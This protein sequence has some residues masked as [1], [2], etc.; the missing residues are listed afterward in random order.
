MARI[1]VRKASGELAPFDPEKIRRT[2]MHAGASPELTDK[3]VAQV[4]K[5]IYNGI[6]TSQIL[7]MTVSLLRKERPE[8]AARY[9]LKG[10]IMRLGPA[11]FEFETLVAEILNRYGYRTQRDV[12]VSGACVEHEIDIVAQKVNAD[13]QDEW[14][15]MECK[16]HNAPGIFTGLKEAM[17]T[18][19]RFIDLQ[20]GFKMGRCKR[21]DLGWLVSNTKFSERAIR[22]ATCK[23]LVLMGWS[24]PHERSLKALL[25]G[26]N[27]YPI[28][29]L[30]KL[31]RPTQVKLADVGLMLCEDLVEKSLEDLKRLTGVPKNKLQILAEEAQMV[32]KK[33][34]VI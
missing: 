29:V 33:D 27:L 1:L 15:M 32:M 19:A 13:N 16:Y 4:T 9:D 12:W 28:T 20:E 6:P 7:K 24:Y 17:Y 31:D 30:T 10:A 18:W 11:G 25:E 22:Y 3:I 21:F 5:S 14:S 34:A 23:R 8:V 26:K 2:C